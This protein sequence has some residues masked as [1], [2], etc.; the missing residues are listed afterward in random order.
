MQEIYRRAV[1]VVRGTQILAGP[2]PPF[3]PFFL[4]F[5]FF[6]F[7]F[8]NIGLGQ[9]EPSLREFNIEHFWHTPKYKADGGSGMPH[10]GDVSFFFSAQLSIFRPSG[11]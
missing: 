3:F 9:P 11:S 4:L 7:F 8:F 1:A 10:V 5:F 6:F 2:R